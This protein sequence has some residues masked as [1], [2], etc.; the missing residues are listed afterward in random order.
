RLG[1][2]ALV[3][4]RAPA[5]ARPGNELERRA[6]GGV[7]MGELLVGGHIVAR[8]LAREG[9]ETVFTLCGGHVSP[10][11]DGCLREGIDIVDTR[12]EQ[13]AVHAADAWARLSRSPGVAILTAGPGVTDGVTGIANAMKAQVPLVVL[14]G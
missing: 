1:F 6:R 9:V 13:A 14:G 3:R 2:G 11:Y 10:I 12:H 4:R 8:Q 7:L 5:A